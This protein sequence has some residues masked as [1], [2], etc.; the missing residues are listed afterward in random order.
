MTAP[1]SAEAQVLMLATDMA[2]NV[3][4]RVAVAREVLSLRAEVEALRK[5]LPGPGEVVVPREPTEHMVI[6]GFEAVSDLHDSDHPDVTFGGCRKAARSAR[7]C[8]AAML[9]AARDGGAG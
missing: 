7:V 6:A 2:E 9:S 3:S 1:V 5:K 8:Y 4:L